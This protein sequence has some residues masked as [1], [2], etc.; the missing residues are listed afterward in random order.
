MGPGSFSERPPGAETDGEAVSPERFFADRRE[1]GRRLAGAL[2]S[3]AGPGTLVLGVPRGG[4][5]VAAEVARALGAPLDVVVARKI[6]APGEPELAVGA[7]VGGEAEPLV[8]EALIRYLG[9]PRHYLQRAAAAERS[10]IQRRTRAYRGERPP[11]AL[12]GRVVIVVD[13]GIATGYTMRAA[14]IALRRQGP[15]RLVVAAPVAPPSTCRELERFAD[16]VVCLLQPDPFMA[17]GAWYASF[18]QVDDAEVTAL[19]R[20]AERP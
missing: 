18:D 1:A 9:I 14:L 13:D 10:E 2:A 4:V 16:Q 3:L 17:V 5:V 20:S 8:D 12:E 11:P 19:L 15:A 7:V 6:G